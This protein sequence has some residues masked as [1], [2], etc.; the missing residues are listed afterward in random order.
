MAKHFSDEF[1]DKW[2]SLIDGVNKERV[3]I[4][5]IDKMILKL[6]GNKQRT[7][8][9]GRLLKKGFDIDDIEEEVGAKLFEL[10]DDIR[11]VEFSMNLEHV[12][13]TVQPATDDLLKNLD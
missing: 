2:E 6:R 12:A 1:R 3:P 13:D 7:I 8:N 5:F 4:E 9:I 10:E 11:S